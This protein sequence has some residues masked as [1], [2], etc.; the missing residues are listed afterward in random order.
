MRQTPGFDPSKFMLIPYHD[1]QAAAGHGSL[2]LHENA[3]GLLAL[4]RDWAHRQFGLDSARLALI[5]VPDDGM[6]PEILKSDFL[7][8]DLSVRKLFGEAIYL[9]TRQ[10]KLRIRR[11]HPMPSGALVVDS[12]NPEY[13]VESYSP[14]F[15]HGIEIIGRV[16]MIL[17][18]V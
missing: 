1:A 6:Q 15:E 9:H 5:E 7:L 2:P 10:D 18:R 4:R 12:G 17:R 16:V 11:F 14:G 3:A 13:A 8:A